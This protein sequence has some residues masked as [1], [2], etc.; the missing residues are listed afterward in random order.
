MKI[1]SLPKRDNKKPSDLFSAKCWEGTPFH[2]K[3]P[4]VEENI[5]LEAMIMIILIK[6]KKRLE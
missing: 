3:N 2:Q 6:V 1:L 4:M 5:Y